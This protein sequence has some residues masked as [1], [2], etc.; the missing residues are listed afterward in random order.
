[1]P[2]RVWV[3]LR[4]AQNCPDDRV[5]LGGGGGG[6]CGRVCEVVG[7]GREEGGKL[8]GGGGAGVGDGRRGGNR[9]I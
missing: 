1:M 7:G 4:D 6:G 5:H 2:E 8:G 9:G 3:I